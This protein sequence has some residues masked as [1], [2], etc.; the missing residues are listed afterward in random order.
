MMEHQ[1]LKNQLRVKYDYEL[2]VIPTQNGAWIHSIG[3]CHLVLKEMDLDSNRPNFRISQISR[4]L[5]DKMV[6]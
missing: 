3:S 5:V 1:N 6:F 2:S 4:I